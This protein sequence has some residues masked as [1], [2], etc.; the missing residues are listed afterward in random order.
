MGTARA[1]S[2]LAVAGLLST[3]L[4]SHADARR[5][6]ESPVGGAPLSATSTGNRRSTPAAVG[7][8]SILRRRRSEAAFEASR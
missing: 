7:I 1:V 5:L 6:P 2:V 3:A 8:D 4:I